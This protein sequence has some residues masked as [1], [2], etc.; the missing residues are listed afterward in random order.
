MNNLSLIKLTGHKT[1]WHALKV[2]QTL[3]NNL[4]S[5]ESDPLF[6]ATA[7]TIIMISGVMKYDIQYAS[8]IS[9]FTTACY[10]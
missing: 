3:H 6:H 2:I 8:S 9:Q 5:E 1:V 10:F 7:V 4:I